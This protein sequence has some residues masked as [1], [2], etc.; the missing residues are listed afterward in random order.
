MVT[1][2]DIIGSILYILAISAVLVWVYRKVEEDAHECDIDH[3][4]R[5]AWASVIAPYVVPPIYFSVRS[6]LSEKTE[7]GVSKDIRDLVRET[8]PLIIIFL[9]IP[10]VLVYSFFRGSIILGVIAGILFFCIAF[11]VGMR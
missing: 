3:P 9:A 5:W 1:L 8:A 2:I 10:V 4:Q 6:R 11:V 7:G